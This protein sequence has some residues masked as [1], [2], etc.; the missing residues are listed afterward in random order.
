MS[1]NTLLRDDKRLKGAAIAR[2]KHRVPVEDVAAELQ[3]PIPLVREWQESMDSKDY[4]V[5][6]AEIMGPKQL[7]L[8][9]ASKVADGEVTLQEVKTSIESAALKL[10]QE[11]AS[12]NIIG[13]DIERART[14]NLLSGAMATLYNALFNKNQTVNILNNSMP[15]GSAPLSKFIGRD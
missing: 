2:L 9:V 11:V 6:E 1:Q 8:M 3:L 14:V 7:Q 13:F 4:H 5:A 10:A 15:T 12:N